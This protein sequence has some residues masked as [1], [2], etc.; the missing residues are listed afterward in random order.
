MVDGSASLN[1]EQL[2]DINAAIGTEKALVQTKDKTIAANDAE[3]ARLKQENA[4]LTAT[5]ESLVTENSNLKDTITELN[6][7][8][9]PPAQALHNGDPVT[10]EGD[11][12]NPKEYCET[13]MKKIYG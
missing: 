3:I 6:K 9:T 2:A 1:Q 11:N 5:K 10:E 12:D 4:S 13:I 7:K 8:P